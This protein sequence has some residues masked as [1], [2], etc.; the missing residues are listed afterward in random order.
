MNKKNL[1]LIFSIALVFS[2]GTSAQT[3]FTYGTKTATKDEFLK[4]FNKN[5]DTTG[6]RSQKIAE[7]L[8]MYVNFRLK[9]QAAYDEKLNA[10]SRLKMEAD[11]FKSQLTENFINNKANINEL[12]HEAFVRSQKDILLQQVFIPLIAGEDTATGWKLANNALTDLKAGKDFGEVAAS[13]ATDPATKQSKGIIG[14]VTVFGLSYP[15]ENIVYGLT[16]GTYSG[17]FRS[18]AGFHIFKNARE[19]PAAGTRKIQQII[20]PVP[21]SFS[22][23]EDLQ[24]AR[25]ADSVYALLQHGAAFS[26]MQ[27]QYSL[28]ADPYNTNLFTE[29]GVGQYDTEFE[30]IIY[31]IEKPDEFTQP[32][33]NAYG[34][35][36][37]KL[38]EAIPVIKDENDVINYAALQ[39]KVQGNNRLGV[40]KKKL[41]DSWYLDTKYKPATYNTEDL[42]RF[43]DSA[44][45][46]GKIPAIT[47]SIKPSTVL[48]EF[49][50]QKVTAADFIKFAQ[51]AKEGSEESMT[52]NSGYEEI[53]SIFINESLNKYYRDHIDEFNPA[54]TE[55]MIE[56]ND[57]NMLFATMDKHVWSKAADDSAGLANYYKINKEKYIW[58]PS[59]S[60]LV[61]SGPDKEMVQQIADTLKINSNNWRNIIE[62]YN[63]DVAAD[64]SRFENGQFPVKQEVLM[65]EGFQTVPESNESGDSYTFI[66]VIKVYTAPSPRSFDE[67]RGM[68]I[69]DYQQV[70]EEKWLKELRA[71]YPVKINQAVL[72]TL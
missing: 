6:S 45:N 61:I 21:S 53:M 1:L 68:I 17:I 5:P 38:I 34:Y 50:K 63:G 37:V 56:F 35:N 13:Y 25:L 18:K 28:G 22:K 36:I 30:R 69:N 16:P 33:R 41:M 39:E 71:K 66:R 20:F 31:G 70:L 3:L 44:I 54:I 4:A 26:D 2:Q 57:A 55:Q 46:T 24:M 72:K 11:D 65:Q 9:L 15:I 32:F 51:L 59:L 10:D 8:D 7:Y 42:W 29:I 27:K 60:A 14:Y 19:R 62:A 47:K 12:V 49:A 58:G 40:A 48:F 23:E 43:T 67:A 64:S 52:E